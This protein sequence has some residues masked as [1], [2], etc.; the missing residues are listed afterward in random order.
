MPPAGEKTR[1]NPTAIIAK[2]SLVQ[3]VAGLMNKLLGVALIIYAARQLGTEGF[4][5]YAFVLSMHAIFYILTD[6]GL[7]TLTTR[8]LSQQPEQE[9]RYLSNVV[10][11]RCLL[12]L[13]AGGGMIA[14]VAVLGHPPAIIALTA[15]L[16]ISFVFNSNIDTATAVFNAHQRM[17]ITSAVSV[18]ANTFRVTTS[19]GAL[20]AGGD[21]FA[22]IWIHTL[23]TAVHMGVLFGLLFYFI[24]PSWQ[25]DLGFWV[26]LLKQAYPLALANLFSIIYFRVDTVM[27]ASLKGQEEVGLYSAAYRL[28]EFTLI[29]PAYYGGAIFPV[30]S[31]SYERNPQRFLL[32]Y[33][34]SLK[35]MWLLSLPLAAGTAVLAH[36]FMEVLYGT[37]Y[38]AGV[39]VLSVLIWT[40]VLIAANSVNAPY[41]I[42]MGK[43]RVVTILVFISML[44]NICLNAVFIPH[45]GMVGAAW[46]TLASEFLNITLFMWALRKPLGMKLR[47]ARHFWRPAVAAGLMVAV[48]RWI[49][50]WDL[51]YQII[52][53]GVCYL[54]ALWILRVFD[55]VDIELFSRILRPTTFGGKKVT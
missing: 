42:V 25:L 3:F 38:S 51:G 34:R 18:V 12:S 17:E 50:A 45:Y 33:R 28:L 13:L 11:L 24:K 5:Q 10:L 23:Y 26:R 16:A 29:F 4:G 54:A 31:S 9:N 37:Q 52:L 6:F 43:Q 32:I 36:R 19:L 49:F 8:D 1:L 14:T 21:V 44:M 30:I 47:M 7:G 20:A 2:N 41:L 35:Y 39:P 53:G 15:I 40:L 22:L 48:L 55:E 27:L 46:V